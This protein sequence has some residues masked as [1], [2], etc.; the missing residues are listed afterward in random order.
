MQEL[1]KKQKDIIDKA[2]A[3]G[4]WTIAGYNFWENNPDLMQI[5]ERIHD[6]DTKQQTT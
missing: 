4:R 5:V 1:T 2:V 6:H 3:D